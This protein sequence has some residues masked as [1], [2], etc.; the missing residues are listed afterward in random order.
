MFTSEDGKHWYFINYDNDTVLGLDNSGNISYPPTITRNT[1]SG[2]D[3]AYAGHE[4]KLWN[5]LEGDSDFMTYYV[6]E[7]DN[8]LFGGGLKYDNALKYFNTN[9]SDKWCEV[10]YNEDANYKYV[11]PYIS[12]VVNELPK[13]HGSRKAHR[14]WWL[15]KRFQLMDAKF[16]NNNYKGKHIHLKLDG[17]PGAEFKIKSSDYMYFGCEYNKNP[18]VMG[19]ELNKGEEYTFYKPSPEEDEVNGKKFAQGDPIYIY[20][21]LYIEELDLSKVSEYIYVLEF[22]KIVDE[23]ISPRMKKLIIGGK[24][25]AKALSTLSGFNALK[26]LEYLDLT[27]IDYPNI[28]ISELLMLKTLILTDSTINTLIIPDGCLIEDL[29]ISEHLNRLNISNSAN[30]K[31]ENIQGF[32][33]IHVPIINI[34]NSPSLTNDYG[35]YYRWVQN[36][37]PGDELHLSGLYW[38][39]VSPDTLIEFKK[40][41]DNG[42]VLN[43]K[44]KISISDPTIEQV[45]ALRNLFGKDC[46]TNNSELWISAPESVFIHGP[47]E[48]RSGDSQLFT[49]TIF[50]ET[51]G[52]VEWQIEY[53]AEW[54]ESI[55]S[56]PDN[57]GL[58]KTIED[59]NANHTIILKAIHKPKDDG[60][61]VHWKAVT[62]EVTLKKVIYSTSGVINGNA[63][64]KKDENF[65]LLL[66]PDKYNG[67]YTTEWDITGDSF[68]NGDIALTNKKNNSVTVKYVNNVIFEAC[69]LVAKVTNKNGTYHEVVL[70]ITITDE[71]VLMTSTSNPEVI[72][73]CYEKG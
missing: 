33:S 22:G 32:N 42:G 55:V 17:S 50:S 49:T 3:Y 21:P 62:Y 9:Q 68:K 63:T 72:Q 69:S 52:T 67:D 23:V 56:N 70:P 6:P 4:S 71:S 18:W 73:I 16:N 57:T 27:G 5:M 25:S 24:K 7:V 61:S 14:T 43:L 45:D 19:V 54:V 64:I 13:M 53:G 51:P 30:L 37:K 47:Q 38:D 46:F 40:I 31:L 12:G 60:N 39:E 11:K 35:F 34:S 36:S 28:D 41:V 59:E 20:S 58:L 15:S 10:I 29:H 44:G 66:G 8:A 2:A 48:I 26:N 65:T 1:P